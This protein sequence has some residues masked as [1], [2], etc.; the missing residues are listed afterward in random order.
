MSEHSSRPPD[1]F[2][3]T[4][5]SHSWSN[6]LQTEYLPERQAFTVETENSRYEL[7]ILSGRT[8]DVLV[9]GGQFFPEETAA[10]L[11]GSS[12]GG[13]LLKLRGIYIG[14]R[15]ELSAHDQS[16]ITSR[17]RSIGLVSVLDQ[18][19]LPLFS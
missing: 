18:P 4:W 1:H 8:G 17:V 19:P 3:D 10:R 11:T 9:R 12:L 6:G 15:M 7:T 14:Y 13:G 5:L 16:I 2:L